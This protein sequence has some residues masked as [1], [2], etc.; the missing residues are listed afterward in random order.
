VSSSQDPD[1]ELAVDDLGDSDRVGSQGKGVPSQGAVHVI[2][3]R[4]EGR[5]VDIGPAKTGRGNITAGT[6][7]R[8]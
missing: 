8:C 3:V 1:D 2:P 5:L 7:I 4:E 6:L